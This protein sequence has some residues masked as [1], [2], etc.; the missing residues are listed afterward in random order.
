MAK[1][2]FEK[3]VIICL[4]INIFTII[5]I[6]IVRK[7]LPPIIPLF[8]GLPVSEEELSISLGLAIPPAISIALIL[9]NLGIAKLTKDAFLKKI[10]IG[11]IIS[12]TALSLIAVIKTILLVGSF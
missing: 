12:L 9:V 4:L 2:F 11:L 6:I 1:N 5:S 10:F 3:I 7:N 8:Y